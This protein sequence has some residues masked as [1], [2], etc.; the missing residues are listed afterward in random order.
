[1][2]FSVTSGKSSDVCV[3]VKGDEKCQWYSF[4]GRILYFSIS[5]CYRKKQK[6]DLLGI[7]L[8]KH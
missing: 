4:R 3:S 6:Y 2:R 8:L 5:K 1:M 7:E